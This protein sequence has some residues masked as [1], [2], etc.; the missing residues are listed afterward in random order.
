MTESFSA[1]NG[2]LR[3]ETC[4]GSWLIDA[5]RRQ[6][7]RVERGTPVTFVPPRAWRPYHSLHVGD[8]GL[9]R[10]VLDDRGVSALS[11]WLHG[12]DCTRCAQALLK[13]A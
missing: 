6:F 11:A 10:L 13:P 3:V 9:V 4:A 12:D 2:V 5:R 7:C 1:R 8:S